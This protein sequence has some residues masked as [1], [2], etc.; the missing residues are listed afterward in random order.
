MPQ[1]YEY[2]KLIG[3]IAFV[4]GLFKI[5]LGFLRYSYGAHLLSSFIIIGIGVIFYFIGLISQKITE[6]KEE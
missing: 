5:I 2:V 6:A 3:I 4:T 1:T